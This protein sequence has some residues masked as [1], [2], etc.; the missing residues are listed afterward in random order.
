MLDS[1]SHHFQVAPSML[2]TYQFNPQ[3]TYVIVGGLNGLGGEMVKWMVSRGARYFISLS[4]S[5]VGN[6]RSQRLVADAAA[7]GIKIQTP[8]CDITDLDMLRSVMQQSSESMPPIM[9][10]IQGAMII[11][12]LPKHPP[13][14]SSLTRRRTCF[15]KG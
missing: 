1:S 15:L 5:G 2:P 4:R 13:H 3:A 10:C 9:G 14:L 11:K 6:E 8:K 12:V 7:Q